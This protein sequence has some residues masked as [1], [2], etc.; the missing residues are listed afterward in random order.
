MTK[1]NKHF[2]LYQDTSKGVRYFNGKYHPVNPDSW[3]KTFSRAERFTWK[4]LCR[5]QQTYGVP[6]E[7]QELES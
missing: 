3:T 6:I 7:R 1:D 4:E 2:I 5:I